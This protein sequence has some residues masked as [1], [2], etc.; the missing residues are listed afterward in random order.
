[1]TT[2]GA[3]TGSLSL[4]GGSVLNGAVGGAVGLKNI[5]VVGGTDTTG[6]SA[7]ITGAVDAYNFTLGTN[8]LNI[9]GALTIANIGPSGV[10]NTTLGSP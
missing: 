8:T 7:T 4:G 10:I 3:N 1:T 6:V 2:V 9:G 5:S